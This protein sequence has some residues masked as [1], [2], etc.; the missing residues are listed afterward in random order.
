M[1]AQSS[2]YEI[3]EYRCKF[4]NYAFTT[5]CSQVTH[6]LKGKCK[7]KKFSCDKCYARFARKT[8]LNKHVCG[9]QFECERCERRFKREHDLRM[10]KEKQTMP[11]Q[12]EYECYECGRK[13]RNSTQMKANV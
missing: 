6:E 8:T 7:D 12:K 2:E 4:C 3:P 1:E 9:R 11:C 13:C 5:Y 10:H